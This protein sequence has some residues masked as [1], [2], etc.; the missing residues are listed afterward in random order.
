MARDIVVEVDSV[1]KKYCRSLRRSMWYGLVDGLR[2]V[3]GIRP[4]S[5]RLRSQEFWAVDEVSFDVRRGECL[6]LVGPNGAG[7]STLLT[8]LNGIVRPDR[9]MI[10]IRGRTAPLIGVGA[11]FHPQLTGRENVYVNAAILGLS[12]A[13]TDAVFD[14]IVA[15]ADIGK[16]LDSPVKFYSSGMYVRLGFSVAVHVRPDLLLIDEILSVGDVRFQARCFN[17]IGEMRRA[18][19]AMI[20]VSHNMHHIASFCDR[21][22]YLSEGR[23]R[24]LAEPEEALAAYTSDMMRSRPKEAA[25]IGT[26]MDMVNGT[27]RMV[28]TGVDFLDGEDRP[29]ET[30][31]RDEPITVRVHYTSDGTVNNPLLDLVIRDSSPGNWF[32]ATNRDLGYELGQIPL[33]GHID[34]GFPSLPANNQV[35]SFYLTLWD[36][37]HYEQF[38][39]KR[40]IRLQVL[41]VPES[42]GRVLFDC[43]WRNVGVD[44]D[45]SSDV[46]AG[47]YDLAAR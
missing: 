8:M 2:D 47:S 9:G 21:V 26:D 39:W 27:G 33:A 41:G 4:P 32:Q 42:S 43:T 24:V 25:E 18:G 30:I 38:D 31:Q 15:F 3:G 29:V 1:A 28:I 34:I 5:A 19:T 22:L 46:P 10:R 7:K 14:E 45:K 20:F 35:L 40:H 37:N 6:G 17:R 23:P 36:S 16:Y 13:E 12:K 11:G 44:P